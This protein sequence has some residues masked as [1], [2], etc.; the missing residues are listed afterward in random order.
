MVYN[1]SFFR[2]FPMPY[3]PNNTWYSDSQKNIGF[4]GDDSLFVYSI[5]P[6]YYQS[7]YQGLKDNDFEVANNTLNAIKNYQKKYGLDVLPS[8]TKLK[9]EV[10]YNESRVFNKLSYLYALVGVFMLFLLIAQVFKYRLW[11][12]RIIQ[13]FFW[14]IIVGFFTHTLGLAGRWIISG[15]APWSNAYE[16]VIYIAWAT[17]LAG[18]IFS[19]KSKMSM[20]ATAVVSSLLLMVAALNWLDPEITNLVPVL[21]SYWL[22]I[23]VAI[24]T[25]SYGF[26]ALGALLGFLSLLIMILQSQK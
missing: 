22:L 5:L 1:G 12:N 23:H 19:K 16:S 13:L 2:F 15:H 4:A 25:A 18:F 14:I 24:I 8:E 26:L 10:F 11:I 7:I 21:N 9:M 3:D 17:V 20:A 6:I